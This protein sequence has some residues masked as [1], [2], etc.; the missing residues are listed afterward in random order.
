[1]RQLHYT[2]VVILASLL[3][4]SSVAQSN[5]PNITAELLNELGDGTT[6]IDV[7]D[8]KITCSPPDRTVGR[9]AT[10]VTTH[11]RIGSS[12]RE[13]AFIKLQCTDGGWVVTSFM[14]VKSDLS[15]EDRITHCAECI[16]EATFNSRE[17]PINPPNR[18]EYNKDTH[19]LSKL[20]CKLHRRHCYVGCW[21]PRGAH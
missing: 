5:C 11:S 16:D 8:F 2:L 21:A 18:L 10:V 12:S 14:T 20:M 13:H 6:P 19:C 4:S 7:Q 15:V 9:F 17:Y 1:M 3:V